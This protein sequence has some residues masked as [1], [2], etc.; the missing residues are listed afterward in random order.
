MTS[1]DNT[2]ERCERCKNIPDSG[3]ELV[4]GV[5]VTIVGLKK[6]ERNGENNMASNTDQNH[7]RR[8]T[9]YTNTAIIAVLAGLL[10]VFALG[11]YHSSLTVQTAGEWLTVDVD[12]GK[13]LVGGGLQTIAILLFVG[14]TEY[15]QHNKVEL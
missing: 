5:C 8:M 9:I 1:E 10:F 15:W 12:S 6:F 13:L 4:R 14:A 3:D 2:L 11:S 7:A